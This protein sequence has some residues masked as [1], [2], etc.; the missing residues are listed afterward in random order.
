MAIPTS[1]WVKAGAS[2]IPSPTM[3]I[4]P[5]LSCNLLISSTLPS[6]R[7]SATMWSMPTSLAMALAVLSLSPVIMAVSNPNCFNSRIAWIESPFRASA[8]AM[9]PAGWPST[10]TSMA[11]FASSSSRVISSF[12]SSISIPPSSSSRRLP[13]STS[14]SFIQP[15]TP[16]PVRVANS[17]SSFNSNPF[18]LAALTM[19]RPRG[20]S[21]P[22]STLA[23]ICS[24]SSSF[25][26]FR[27]KR[28]VTSGFPLVIV[29][30][31][32]KTMV[33]TSFINWIASP[34]R[35]RTPFSAP[36]PLPTINAVGVARPRA[37][38]QAITRTATV[39]KIARVKGLKS[40]LTQGRKPW[41]Q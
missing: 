9:I 22:A 8:T 4:K 14:L 33:W 3:A 10:A 12:N 17:L 39:A 24:N 40:G 27:V 11:V 26:P 20:C 29:P 23:A 36:M 31:L 21:E 2:F 34:L 37:Q 32:S 18:S 7:T 15:L 30:V 25:Q 1:A 41:A 28:S 35:I 5:N 13:T 19:A 6:G 16:F 38:G